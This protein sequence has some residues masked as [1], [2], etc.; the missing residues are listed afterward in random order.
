MRK[1]NFCLQMT[2]W[3]MQHPMHA[4]VLLPGFKDVYAKQIG[5]ALELCV[6]DTSDGYTVDHI[7][8]RHFD[9]D[10]S[11]MMQVIQTAR[12]MTKEKHHA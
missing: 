1:G 12:L 5:S 8:R 7:N 6:Q 9:C 4:H 2:G 10:Q 11:F 3:K